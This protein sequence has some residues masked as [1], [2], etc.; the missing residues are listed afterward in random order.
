MFC[1]HGR[2]FKRALNQDRA[3]KRAYTVQVH[4]EQLVYR[5]GLELPELHRISTKQRKTASGR[6]SKQGLHRLNLNN[7]TRT[8][9]C[10]DIFIE[11]T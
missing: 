9:L 7:N 1:S 10:G 2:L 6:H 4:V 8:L 5:R 3:V 11:K